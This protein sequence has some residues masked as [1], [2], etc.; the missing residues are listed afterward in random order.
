MRLKAVLRTPRITW[1]GV[2]VRDGGS[3]NA[4]C[5]AWLGAGHR[6]ALHQHRVRQ[7]EGRRLSGRF[8]Q[9]GR[10]RESRLPKCHLRHAGV[11]AGRSPGKPGK[12]VSRLPI[13][14]PA[15]PAMGPHFDGPA[16][17]VQQYPT[18]QQLFLTS[19]IFMYVTPKRKSSVTK[20][21]GMD[22]TAEPRKKRFFCTQIVPWVEGFE[23]EVAPSTPMN[24]HRHGSVTRKNVIP[25][26]Q[27]WIPWHQAWCPVPLPSIEC[28]SQ[29]VVNTVIPL[30]PQ[31]GRIFLQTGR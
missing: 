4:F 7:E 5:S 27:A 21:E 19:R 26:H 28:C 23:S 12:R 31:R 3:E 20:K 9:Q 10:R 16:R 22:E 30:S 15:A 25:W 6:A 2:N 11:R 14:V 1:Q 13:H 18:R 29:L 24:L 17:K 8:R